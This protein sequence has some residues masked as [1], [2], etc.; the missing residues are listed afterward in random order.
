MSYL[1]DCYNVL[2]H[3]TFNTSGFV[4]TDVLWHHICVAW[5]GT[6]GKWVFHGDG[7]KKREGTGLEPDYNIGFGYLVIGR[8]KGSL[9]HFNMW[10]FF[11]E[12][13]SQIDI[14]SP[15]TGNI[16]QWPDVHA[17]RVGNVGKNDAS[18]CKFTGEKIQS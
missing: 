4:I 5:F 1:M 9:T 2:F 11:I 14:C 7:V 16:V 10:D 15:M 12:D 18:P 13:A 17:W 3:S 8:F 6:N